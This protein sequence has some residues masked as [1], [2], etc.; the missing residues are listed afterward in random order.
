M[1]AIHD[2]HDVQRGTACPACGEPLKSTW[3]VC[4]VCEA[5]VGR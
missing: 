2:P 1:S 3:K 5:P 4:P